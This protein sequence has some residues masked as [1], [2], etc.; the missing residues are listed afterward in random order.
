MGAHLR[1]KR[2]PYSNT[3]ING[4]ACSVCRKT[5]ANTHKRC[6]ALSQSRKEVI[7]NGLPILIVTNPHPAQNKNSS[8]TNRAW[9]RSTKS[10][11]EKN[12]AVNRP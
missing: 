5:A 1:A 6:T 10:T 11:R 9:V 8:D 2:N 4:R 7:D 3:K 12:I